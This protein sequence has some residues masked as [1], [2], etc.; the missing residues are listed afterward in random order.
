[1]EA[2]RGKQNRQAGE[3]I[4]HRQTNDKTNGEKE[5]ELHASE[6]IGSKNKLEKQQL[7]QMESE[8][9]I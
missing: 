7:E 8:R 9:E 1:M 4:Q 6:V 5:H 3:P 2:C